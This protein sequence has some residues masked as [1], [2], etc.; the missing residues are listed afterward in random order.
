MTHDRHRTP[1]TRVPLEAHV[2]ELR[3]RC[4]AACR[5]SG[6]D[7]LYGEEVD[8]FLESAEEGDCFY[9]EAP[10]ELSRPPDDEG[11]EHQ[12]WFLPERNT[13]SKITWPGFFGKLVVFSSSDSPNASPIGFRPCK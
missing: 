13:Y 2:E 6:G 5:F 8:I 4:E 9:R 12:V 3:R 10:P 1:A 7:T 11:N